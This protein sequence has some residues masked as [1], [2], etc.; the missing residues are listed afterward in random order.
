MEGKS[1]SIMELDSLS[2]KHEIEKKKKLNSINISTD[3]MNID[4]ST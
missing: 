4:S 1:V 3:L 2:E